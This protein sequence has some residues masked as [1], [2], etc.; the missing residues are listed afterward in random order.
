MARA[1]KV[2]A[3]LDW[4][5][6][7]LRILD[8]IASRHG[9]RYAID[10]NGRSRVPHDSVAILAT[11]GAK[12]CFCDLSSSSF[13][14]HGPSPI[15]LFLGEALAYSPRVVTPDGKPVAGVTVAV[16]C[17]DSPGNHLFLATTGDDGGASF[18]V[19]PSLPPITLARLMIASRDAVQADL[20]LGGSPQLKL[21]NCA[22]V[23]VV[24]S[25]VPPG[26]SVAWQLTRT[27]SDIKMQVQSRRAP[28]STVHANA[29]W[30]QPG[31]LWRLEPIIDGVRAAPPLDLPPLTAGETTVVKWEMPTDGRLRLRVL[32]S[33]REPLQS[34]MLVVRFSDGVSTE[35]RVTTNA[36][37]H[38]DLPFGGGLEVAK[39][40]YLRHTDGLRG[41]TLASVRLALP[42]SGAGGLDLGDVV[43]ADEKV[44][45]SGRV[46]DELG[47]PVSGLWLW[48][49]VDGHDGRFDQRTAITAAD[50]SF[51]IRM[52]DPH[53]PQLEVRVR[54]EGWF[55]ATAT[56]QIS[57]GTSSE[58][59]VVRPAAFIRFGLVGMPTDAQGSFQ[60]ECRPSG[61]DERGYRVDVKPAGGLVRVPAG[62][63]DLL[64]RWFEDGSCVDEIKNVIVEPGTEVHD[65]R[66]MDYD[67]RKWAG[68]LH[69]RLRHTDST[70]MSQC[71]VRQ[72]FT[73]KMGTM[74]RRWQASD[75]ELTL[76]VPKHGADLTLDPNDES[77]A[78][79]EL[80]SAT[81]NRV[82]R[83]G[84]GARVL[85][86]LATVPVVPEGVTIQGTL[87]GPES[88]TSIDQTEFDS[89]GHA[90]LYAP[91]IGKWRVLL[92]LR[93]GAPSGLA[94][95]CVGRF[96]RGR[97]CGGA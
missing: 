88:D 38:L 83:F 27:D 69:L 9:S 24:A 86:M 26:S 43:L 41:A 35:Y 79:V 21:P 60:I 65:P 2:R 90:Y 31:P 59:I 57:T 80:R 56:T 94:T 67:W 34:A 66:L 74:Q 17:K 82:V 49:P 71:T 63:W 89:A 15:R 32:S 7:G 70:A 37:G 22:K 39:K 76:F 40:L 85:A 8:A 20:S 12:V 92:S 13:S 51:S 93:K 33:N 19:P 16:G 77:L 25:N 53:P 3:E 58:K 73:W 61:G 36:Q 5:G 72:T 81:G 46:L 97:A 62:H 55:A 47:Q 95:F 48:V 78:P 1:T 11:R 42:Q 29:E 50:G 44:A 68:I 96:V 6:Q 52:S 45:A 14:P 91:S 18:D 54:D 10:G 30:V 23:S 87:V 84:K 4:P 28:D 75:G 64:F